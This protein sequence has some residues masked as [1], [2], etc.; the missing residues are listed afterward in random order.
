[1][2]A[3]RISVDFS[4][5]CG[6]LKPYHAV[7]EGPRTGGVNLFSDVSREFSEIGI[8]L[9]RLHDVE[10]PY[11]S[12]QFVDIH[13]I[14]PDFSKDPSDPESYNFAPTDAYLRAI[15]EAGADIIF[16]LGEST[17]P[18][19]KKLYAKA[20]ADLEKWASICEHIVMH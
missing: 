8:P 20:P 16:R 15:R 11:G 19:P 6:K 2:T 18:F 12:N 3:R 5:K 7:S 13:C 4:K 17:D 9:V 1:M 14:F 10:Y